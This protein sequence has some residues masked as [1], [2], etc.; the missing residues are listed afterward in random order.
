MSYKRKRKGKK[1]KKKQLLGALIFLPRKKDK[2]K[3]QIQL[4]RPCGPHTFEP[5]KK[6]QQI[7]HHSVRPN[8]IPD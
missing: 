4:Y 6:A 5:K 1:K 2:C 7:V 3:I 8:V